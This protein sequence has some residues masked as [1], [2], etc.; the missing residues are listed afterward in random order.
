MRYKASYCGLS[1]RS[2]KQKLPG[3]RRD[4]ILLVIVIGFSRLYLGVHYFTDVIV[5][6]WRQLSGWCSA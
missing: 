3:Q 4:H 1:F 2:R 5:C 6:I